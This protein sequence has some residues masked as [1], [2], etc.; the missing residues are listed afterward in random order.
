MKRKFL[1]ATQTRRRLALLLLFGL[2][3]S[4]LSPPRPVQA[5]TPG[6]ATT[7]PQNP[8]QAGKTL[9]QAGQAAQE[10]GHYHLAEE[11]FQQAITALQK[12]KAQ[13]GHTDNLLSRA[14]MALA[15]NQARQG[16]STQAIQAANQALGAL[17][18]ANNPAE[19]AELLL[20]TGQAYFLL[21]AYATTDT[22]AKMALQ[23]LQAH[24]DSPP[25][26]QVR[27]LEIESQLYLFWN[28]GD[29]AQSYLKE[30][31]KRAQNLKSGPANRQMQTQLK[32]LETEIEAQQG[33]ARQ[34][35]KGLKD[36]ASVLGQAPDPFERG[37]NLLRLAKLQQALGSKAEAQQTYQQAQTLF[38]NLNLPFY[39][40]RALAGLGQIENQAQDFAAAESH[41]QQALDLSQAWPRHIYLWEYESGMGWALLKQGRPQEALPHAEAAVSLLKYHAQVNAD[42]VREFYNTMA[43]VFQQLLQTHLALHDPAHALEV[44]ENSKALQFQQMIRGWQRDVFSAASSGNSQ[45][46]QESLPPDTLALILS[47]TSQ[48]E[49]IHFEV[50][51]QALSGQSLNP[52]TTLREDPE[53]ARLYAQYR[54]QYRLANPDGS[55][56]WENLI[57]ADRALLSNPAS[58]PQERRDLGQLLYQLLLHPHTTQL[59]QFKRLLIIPDGNLALLPFESLIDPKGQYLVENHQV[60]YIQ[61]LSVLGELQ[62]RDYSPMRRSMLALGDPDYQTVSYEH[63]AIRSRQ[64]LLS[65]KEQVWEQPRSPMREVLGALYSPHWAPLPGTREELKAIQKALPDSR[66][67][68]GDAVTEATLKKLSDSGELQQYR[69]IHFATHGL[70]VAHLPELSAL[71]LS[72][73]TQMGADDNYL[74]VPEILELKLHASFV[75]LSA[76]ETGLGKVFQ[77]EGVSGL[78]QAFLA[79]GANQISVSLWQIND[80]S[81]AHFMADLYAQTS[82]DPAQAENEVKRHF[83]HGKFGEKYRHPY[84]WAP[85]V[86]YGRLNP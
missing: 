20:G 63:P 67:I 49:V 33:Q 16:N 82:L 50:S 34:A 75:N 66:L 80:Q 43:P 29:R 9:W 48:G 53:A 17:D 28:K 77:G 30:A 3:W 83:I 7:A 61:S 76:C 65:L 73:F 57:K 84:Y 19:M 25:E 69:M 31:Q 5:A 21:G 14:L 86:V 23:Q 44:Q 36:L 71:V 51:Q 52:Q 74:R 6:T 4:P 78:T 60:Q 41:F 22:Y 64:E 35:Q 79:A 42:A 40:A 1:L 15:Q 62:Q 32:L 59:A 11:R 12:A 58:S 45:W 26:P 55:L 38:Q 70:T 72:Q 81:S 37:Q 10:E 18:H 39:K 13:M 54:E 2:C 8:L 68:T 47:P 46:L 56:N 27:A 24:P 85:Y